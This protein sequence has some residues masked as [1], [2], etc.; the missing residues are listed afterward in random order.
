MP[1]SVWPA[2]VVKHLR[3]RTEDNTQIGRFYSASPSACKTRDI[4]GHAGRKMEGARGL[5]RKC[6]G[7]NSLTSRQI[8]TLFSYN[9][10][11]QKPKSTFSHRS[12][13][14][15][16]R[17]TM[18]SALS[19]VSSMATSYLAATPSATS[20]EVLPAIPSSAMTLVLP[21]SPSYSTYLLRELELA[22]RIVNLLGRCW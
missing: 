7:R 5:Q 17:S 12:D 13:S 14:Y 18:M 16:L 4:G 15:G 21:T 22:V 20:T 10:L 2:R 19:A 6:S 11:F 8:L 3:A 9:F 1:P